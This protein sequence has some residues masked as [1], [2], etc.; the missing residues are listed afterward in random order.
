M[1]ASIERLLMLALL[2]AGSLYAYLYL[3]PLVSE[4]LTA[5]MTKA[6]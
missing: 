4:R 2:I 3:V 6:L 1:Q 5:M